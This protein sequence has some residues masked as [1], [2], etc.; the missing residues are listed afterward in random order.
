MFRKTSSVPILILT[1]TTY[2]SEE[3]LDIGGLDGFLCGAG[4]VA[5][6]RAGGAVPTKI[7]MRS[8]SHKNES[9]L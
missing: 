5:G 1:S 2:F 6:A 3:V 4:V 8:T 9:E 7:S